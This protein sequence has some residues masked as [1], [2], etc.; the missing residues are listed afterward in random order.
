[1]P[2]QPITD[3]DV[4]LHAPRPEVVVVH[5]GGVVDEGAAGLLAERLGQQLDRATHVVLDLDGVQVLRGCG[6]RLLADLQRQA[7]DRGSFLHIAAVEDAGVHD[8]LRM[9]GLDCERPA[10]AVVALLPQS[11]REMQRLRR[12]RIR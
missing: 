1:M 2:V 5:V 3:L 4:R 7:G 11:H 6:A 8:E 12:R 10:D 9:A